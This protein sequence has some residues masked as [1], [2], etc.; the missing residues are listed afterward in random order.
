[1]ISDAHVALKVMWAFFLPQFSK[2]VL[3]MQKFLVIGLFVFTLLMGTMSHSTSQAVD[4]LND[5]QK[6]NTIFDWL[7]PQFPELLKPTPQ[8]TQEISGIIFRYYSATN[9]YMAS[10]QN[11]L[12]FIDH[13]VNLH[14][15]GDVDFWVNHI[16]NVT[17]SDF[18]GKWSGKMTM[19]S[20]SWLMT[21]DVNN[22]SGTL[23]AEVQGV[24]HNEPG[25]VDTMS[26]TVSSG[27]WN[28]RITTNSTNPDCANFDVSGTGK[29]SSDK[30][31]MNLEATGNFCGLRAT[32]SGVLK[33]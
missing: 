31:S 32:I 5:L 30:Q 16:E 24:N 11:Q 3:K 18:V 27:I 7:E 8:E 6:A 14:D 12:F 13:Q 19:T 9:V 26:G 23:S 33:K 10:F 17:A 20:S 15:L 28:F 2:G 4:N 21:L 29:L 1:M 25:R 22:S